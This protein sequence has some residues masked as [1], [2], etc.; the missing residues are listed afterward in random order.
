MLIVSDHKVPPWPPSQCSHWAGCP[1]RCGGQAATVRRCAGP[2]APWLSPGPSCPAPSPLS[3]TLAW[4]ETRYQAANVD[5]DGGMSKMNQK[6]TN[7]T[8][9]QRQTTVGNRTFVWAGCLL[10]EVNNTSEE[11]FHTMFDV[12]CRWL[13]LWLSCWAHMYCYPTGGTMLLKRQRQICRA[14]MSIWQS[15][16]DQRFH[17]MPFQQWAV[18]LLREHLGFSS[19]KSTLEPVPLQQQRKK[20]SPSAF[21]TNSKMLKLL[22]LLP[23]SWNVPGQN[24]EQLKAVLQQPTS[25]SMG[26]HFATV[27]DSTT[28]SPAAP[29]ATRS[30]THLSPVF[31]KSSSCRLAGRWHTKPAKTKSARRRSQ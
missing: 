22:Q 10:T 20:K 21:Y 23:T 25:F 16:R 2:G 19:L 6:K 31:T 9:R 15:R 14:E 30:T 4:T 29:P 3:G 11:S 24:K 17:R 27:A 7:A 1:G 13:L 18:L 5:R 26:P 28:T 8:I 12:P